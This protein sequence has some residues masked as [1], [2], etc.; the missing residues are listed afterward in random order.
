MNGDVKTKQSEATQPESKA[1]APVKKDKKKAKKKDNDGLK[2]P[3]SA[4]MLFNN[5]RRPLL[6]E[7]D[8]SK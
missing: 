6:R 3:L 8:P 1:E 5:E 7:N 4:Y 2:R